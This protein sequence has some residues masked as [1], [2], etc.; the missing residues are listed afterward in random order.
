MARTKSPTLTDGELRLMEVLWRR[1]PSAVAAVAADLPKLSYSTVMTM[2]RILEE[3]GYVR[4][5]KEGRAFV[6]HPLVDRNEAGRSAVRYVLSRFFGNSPE[7]LL[8]NVLKNER[9]EA[10][11]LA[12]LK[13]LIADAK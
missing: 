2:L 1:G 3:K 8:L 4:H 10:K 12:R 11:E 5:T 9:L 6:Y 7:L 13:K